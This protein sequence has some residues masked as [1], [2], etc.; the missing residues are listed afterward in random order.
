VK[1]TALRFFLGNDEPAEQEDSDDE[2]GGP[3]ARDIIMRFAANKKT[4]KAKLK[5]EKAL[6]LLRK[7]KKRNKKQQNEDFSAI[8]LLNDPQSNADQ[9][10]SQLSNRSNKESFETR[11][12]MIIVIAR[13]I[14]IHKLQLEEFY[15]FLQPLLKPHQSEVTKILNALAQATHDQVAPDLLT[16]VVRVI[17]DEFVSERNSSD[18]MA[19]GLQAIREI[20]NRNPHAINPALLQDL[21]CY[22][23]KQQKSV[24]AA[25]RS[26]LQ[27]YRK[28]NPEMLKRKD[29]GRPSEAGRELVELH[30]GRPVVYNSVPNSDVLPTCSE[31]QEDAEDGEEDWEE[32]CV[33]HDYDSDDNEGWIDVSSEGENDN[34]EKELPEPTEEEIEEKKTRA[35]MNSVGRIFSTKEHQ[36]MRAQAALKHVTYGKKNKKVKRVYNPDEGFTNTELVAVENIERVMKCGQST[37]AEKMAL[38]LAGREDRTFGRKRQKLD[39]FASTTNKQKVK[40]KQYMM[41]RHKAIKKQSGRSFR[42]KQIELRKALTKQKTKGYKY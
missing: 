5:R 1:T 6:K 30:Y 27:L 39:P 35:Q 14:G 23:T 9:L 42:E 10:F 34:E 2:A 21:T 36:E 41:V 28:I 22:K 16:S 38:V 32:E 15:P 12:L 8:Q 18:V 7:S 4:Q 17:A 33:A 19:V 37:K 25:S 40:N 11:L 24:M 29:R 3:S 13:L 26:L 31:L 20:C